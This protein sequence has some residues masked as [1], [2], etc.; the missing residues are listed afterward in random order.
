MG[1][2]WVGK[3]EKGGGEGGFKESEKAFSEKEGGRRV[4]WGVFLCG[5]SEK[6]EGEGVVFV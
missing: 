6:K 3:E 4:F 5:L 1:K 2:I